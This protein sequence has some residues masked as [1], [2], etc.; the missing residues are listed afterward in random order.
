MRFYPSAELSAAQPRGA[1]S[2]A[3]PR[4][5]SRAW[6]VGALCLLPVLSVPVLPLIDF[7]A[8]AL[9][10]AILADAGH[11]PWLAEN[12]RSAWALLPN[13][14]LDVLGT[15]L[16]ALVPPLVAARLLVLIV[17]AAPFAG[18]LVLARVLQGR[19][20]A[21]SVALAGVL[22][23]S[24][25]LGWGFANFLLGLGVALAALG[26]WLALERRPARQLLVA[27]PAG[28]VIFF[29]HGFVF[30][31][32][33]LLL[34]AVEAGAALRPGQP[35]R[36]LLLRAFR[37]ALV[38]VI[39]ALL[40]LASATAGGEGGM[41][42]A[43][44]HFAG[45]LQ[46]GGLATRIADEIRLRADAG[47][48]VAE[49]GWP[50]A[51]RLFGLGL[52]GLVAAGLLTGRLQLDRRL[53]LPAALVALLAVGVPPGLFGVGHLPERLPLVLLALFAAGL[54]PV[55]G[56]DRRLARAIAALLPL[57][58]LMVTLA[59]AG[60]A[61]GYRS[62]LAAAERL[63]PRMLAAPAYAADSQDRDSQRRCKPLI[64]LLGLER[65]IAVQTFAN[66]TQQPLRITGPLARAMAAYDRA[67]AARP[68]LVGAD[69]VAALFAAGFD[70]AVLC[71]GPATPA[72]E[73]AGAERLASG[74]GWTIYGAL[75]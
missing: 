37:L 49:S 73:V 57:H 21:L 13:L 44:E 35:R 62:F 60:A 51:D 59:W 30:A 54:A 4:V 25:I 71:H 47:L 10:Y 40:F 36:D 69:Q 70:A 63:P 56:R 1:T 5:W 19:V 52:W 29:I 75:R 48:R 33:G 67:E 11:D 55:R 50:W 68:G 32:W 20:T 14:G 61:D 34:A 45:Y 43:A 42:G 24:F 66:P 58:L 74:P 39:P 23:H 28:V 7:Y 9:R 41:T 3:W 6:L 64:S 38:A 8:H 72:P 22:A 27:V 2:P 31:L 65:G 46:T 15:G 16:F 17:V 26:L 12:Y 18:A 53:R